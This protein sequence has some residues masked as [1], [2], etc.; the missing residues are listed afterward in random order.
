M[1]KPPIGGFFM[2]TERLAA[3]RKNPVLQTQTCQYIRAVLLIIS[4]IGSV[5]AERKS[6]LMRASVK[7]CLCLS[8]AAQPLQTPDG[9]RCTVCCDESA[10]R[11]MRSMR[12]LLPALRTT[13]RK[14]Q[15]IPL[16]WHDGYAPSSMYDVWC[17]PTLPA[18]QQP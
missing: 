2:A 10:N 18:Y 8:Y 17:A 12:L 5:C 4:P 16:C 9:T 11:P 6:P 1:F 3:L 7:P 13:R 15:G 14:R